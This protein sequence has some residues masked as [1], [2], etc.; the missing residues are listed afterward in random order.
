[1]CIR[2]SPYPFPHASPSHPYHIFFVHLCADGHLGC[3]HVLVL[4]NQILHFIVHRELKL[5]EVEWLTW[6]HTALLK[7]EP[8]LRV[9]SSN[10]KCHVL[11]TLPQRPP[12]CLWMTFKCVKVASLCLCLA[13]GYSLLS[14]C[15]AVC[16][17]I[18][19]VE[20][21]AASWQR[22]SSAWCQVYSGSY[23]TASP[24]LS[25]FVLV[26]LWGWASATVSK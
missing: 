14:L 26:Y 18:F 2:I 23:L 12:N 3:F 21:K 8:G 9:S 17:L 16:Y 6:S 24:S 11:F 10:S 4:V 20:R 22:F 13:P 19:L 25:G 1:M 7:A 15:V 5:R